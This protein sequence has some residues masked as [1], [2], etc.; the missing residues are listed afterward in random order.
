LEFDEHIYP[1]TLLDQLKPHVK[2]TPTLSKSVPKFLFVCGKQREKPS[3]TTNRDTVRDYFARIAPNVRV[4]L[5]EDL[6]K[7]MG[8]DLLTFEHFMA[9]VSDL[10]VLFLESRGTAA[11]LGAFASVDSLVKKLL[12]F[13]DKGHLNSESFISY[14]PL[15]KI[16]T[17]GE[18]VIYG[19]MKTPFGSPLFQDRLDRLANQRKM[20]R[21]SSAEQVPF[22]SYCVELL[23]LVGM[24]GPIPWRDVISL[25]KYLKGLDSFDVSYGEPRKTVN[26][27]YALRFLR[28]SGLLQEKKSYLML[29]TSLVQRN[30]CLFDFSDTRLAYFR[31]KFLAR[32]YKYIGLSNL[33]R[34]GVQSA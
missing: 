32:K 33:P 20:I 14:G 3:E 24:F 16:D 4:L 25:F 5:A 31:A 28:F 6:W 19:S 29:D 12:V 22:D 11:E 13:N 17:E 21:P 1:I 9:S 26:A 2:G 23:D 27:A 15:R 8:V 34:L 10:I 18:R 30:L 7:G